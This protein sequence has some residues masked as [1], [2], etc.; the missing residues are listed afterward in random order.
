[1][2]IIIFKILF[3]RQSITSLWSVPNRMTPLVR[4]FKDTIASLLYVVDDNQL[5]ILAA[6]SLWSVD[7]L[8]GFNPEV[9]PTC[10]YGSVSLFLFNIRN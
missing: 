2:Y 8:T 4:E 3:F 10:V 9:S 1:M 5:S 6:I 7:R